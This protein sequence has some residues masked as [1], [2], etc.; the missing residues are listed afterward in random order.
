MG[1]AASAM[2][3]HTEVTKYILTVSMND[4][5]A[6]VMQANELSVAPPM[7]NH[8]HPFSHPVS[9]PFLLPLPQWESLCGRE[10]D[11]PELFN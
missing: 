8:Y 9:P 5:L 11:I 3:G 2:H 1:A 7:T 4:F 6:D 10:W